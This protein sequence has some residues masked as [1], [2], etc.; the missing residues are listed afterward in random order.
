MG[1]DDTVGEMGSRVECSVSIDPA[2]EG[3]FATSLYDFDM[4]TVI[5]ILPDAMHAP[6]DWI[7]VRN[8]SLLRW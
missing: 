8:L 4:V 1:T 7:S 5:Y 6:Q 2:A 3:P